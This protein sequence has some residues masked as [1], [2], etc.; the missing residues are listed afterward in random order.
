MRQILFTAAVLASCLV[1]HPSRLGAQ[2][3]SVVQRGDSVIIHLVDVDLRAAVQALGR[4]LDR[5][6][7][8]GAISGARLTFETPQPVPRADVARLLRG[9]LLSQNVDLVTDSAAGIY[10][11]TPRD[12]VRSP[13]AAQPDAP[14][15]ARGVRLYVI[16]LKHARA[17]DV[18]ATVNSLYGRASALGEPGSQPST[19]ARSLQ[20]QQVPP[21]LPTPN[22]AQQAA[23]PRLRCRR[24]RSREHRARNPERHRRRQ[25]YGS[26][27]R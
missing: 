17:T 5:P 9:L 25:H 12:P 7:V 3:D 14:Q 4:Y 19:L 15:L 13:T 16:H 24:E 2:S 26:R 27:S 21:G 10:R 8:I 6:V 1:M 23:A 22:A 18:A 20:A 11:L